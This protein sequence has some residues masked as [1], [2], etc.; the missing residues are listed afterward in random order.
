M[1]SDRGGWQSKVLPG[2]GIL[3]V[4]PLTFNPKICG[5]DF[6]M[7]ERE[8]LSGGAGVEGIWPC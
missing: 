7:V 4:W 3:H 6:G 2:A 1:G 5:T 8:Q